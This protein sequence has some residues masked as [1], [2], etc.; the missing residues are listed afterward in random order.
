MVSF[1]SFENGELIFRINIINKIS[2][3]KFKYLGFLRLFRINSS[4]IRMIPIKKVI[5]QKKRESH[6]K[7]K[8]SV[9]L[10]E[11]ITLS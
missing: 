3:S 6:I 9:T 8:I 10:E 2:N 4:K 7:M 1:R 5:P 11:G